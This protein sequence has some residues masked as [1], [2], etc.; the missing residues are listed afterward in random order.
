[1]AGTLVPSDSTQAMASLISAYGDEEADD[2]A[3][4]DTSGISAPPEAEMASSPDT[5]TEPA[6]AHFI[7]DDEEPHHSPQDTGPDKPEQNTKLSE[8]RPVGITNKSTVL[9]SYVPD[10]VDEADDDEDSGESLPSVFNIHNFQGSISRVG[11][12]ASVTRTESDAMRTS[13]PSPASINEDDIPLPPEPAGN[14]SKRLQEKI[15]KHYNTMMREGKDLNAEIQRLKEFRN[16]S[17]YE[18]L[19]KMC[20]I[21]EQG[22]NYPPELY[23]PLIWGPQSY[24]DELSRIQTEMLHEKEKEAKKSKVEFQKG[25]KKSAPSADVSA[26][27]VKRKVSKWDERGSAATTN[28]TTATTHSSS[29]PK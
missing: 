14:C 6:G 17:I 11:S 22:T 3:G 18:K 29:K 5:R 1:M 13:S 20:G 23:N 9:V 10:E 21:D 4:L 8:D 16:P 7:S 15:A 27:E 25:V 24:Y 12:T 26:V 19:I 28:S 2:D